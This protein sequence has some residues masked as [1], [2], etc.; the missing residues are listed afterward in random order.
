[1]SGLHRPPSRR[2]LILLIAILLVVVAGTV[3]YLYE[4]PPDT[5]AA[6][7]GYWVSTH[8]SNTASGTAGH[9]WLTVA[10]AVATAP[11]GSV[12]YVRTGT[13]R[14]FTIA[15]TGLTVTSAPGERATIAGR[16]GTRD[17]VLINASGVTLS[18]L[19]I[20]GCVPNKNANAD[21]TG[22]QGSGIR[23]A[24]TTGVTVSGVIVRDSH[25][26]NAGGLPV[27]CYGILV[28]SSRDVQVTGSEVYHNGA[29]ISV[30]HAGRGVVVANNNVHD[31]DV[32]MRNT[33]A[34]DDDFGGYG[35]GAMFVTDDP[36][37]VFRGNVVRRNYG[38]STDYGVDGGGME[39]YDA[40]HTTITGNTFV[41]NNG[42]MET[43]SGSNG[44]CAGTVFS[45]NSASGDQDPSG[46]DSDTGLVLRCGA[47]MVIKGNTFVH[48]SDFTFLLSTGDTFGGSISGLQISGNTVTR[49]SGAVV[50][51]LQYADG[52]P[53]VDI[54]ANR[55]ITGEDSFAVL[56]GTM[57]ETAVTFAVWRSRT[58]HDAAS[59]LL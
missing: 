8:G 2:R 28:T 46:L 54:D 19:T 20:S 50:Y 38:Q 13:Y 56:N 49:R 12:I 32:I 16:A 21:V 4:P 40:F 45:D 17:V 11:T 33:L 42:V 51:R 9:P 43:G 1:M 6:A 7:P 25:G 10:H 41:A 34:A 57:S 18:N 53:T 39:L 26:L 24:S 59:R 15:R 23:I 47:G 52:T 48:L 3:T 37:P 44:T 5:A 29:G 36:G 30:S 14:P 27:G 35:L 55:Y 58:G 22:D 31:Q